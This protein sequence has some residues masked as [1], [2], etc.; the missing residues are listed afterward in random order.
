MTNHSPK[1]M[2]VNLVDVND[3][4]FIS[5][6]QAFV[7][8][9]DFITF[10]RK[11]EHGYRQTGKT[12]NLKFRV[13]QACASVLDTGILLIEPDDYQSNTKRIVISS[14]IHGNETAPIEIVQLLITDIVNLNIQIKHPTLLIMGNPVAMNIVKRFES[15]NLNRLFCEKYRDI[16]DCFEKYRAEKLESYVRAFFS[17]DRSATINYHYDLHTAIRHSKYQKFAIYP[18]QQEKPWDK[19]QLSFM[20][21]CGI[22]T[23]LFGHGATGTFSYFSSV[24]FSA[25]AFTIELGKVKPFGENN[26]DNFIDIRIKLS[27][28]ICDI[29]LL[30]KPFNNDDFNLFSALGDITK[31]SDSFKLFISDQASNFTS[32]PINTLLS[33]DK[34]GEYRTTQVDESIVFPNANVGIGQRAVL[35]VVPT[36]L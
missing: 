12:N 25:H 28:L 21:S 18:Y 17:D 4:E 36:K 31:Y 24:N 30:L 16:A 8:E 13:N 29:P 32:Y 22:N 34:D 1:S 5:D 26:M 7:D 33:S 9:G 2:A 23:I 6:Y 20:A 3:I 15:E 10:T 35:M 27:E 19:E 11:Y 14:G